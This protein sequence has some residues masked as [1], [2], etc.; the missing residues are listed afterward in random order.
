[1]FNGEQDTANAFL[2]VQ[3]GSGGTEAPGWAEMLLRMYLRWGEKRGFAAELIEVSPGEVAGIKE[4]NRAIR[5]RLR[6]RM[7]AHRNGRA[8]FGAQVPFDSG[9]PPAHVV[10]LGVRL[11]RDRRQH[12]HRHRPGRR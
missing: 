10:R 2:E 6:V 1:M 9:S 4:R 8:S 5:R 7:A 11:R 3:A 12:R